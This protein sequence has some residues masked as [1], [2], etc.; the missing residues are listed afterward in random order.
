MRSCRSP[1]LERALDL[2]GGQIDAGKSAA[3]YAYVRILDHLNRLAPERL[4]LKATFQRVGDEVDKMEEK[5]SRLDAAREALALRQAS[6]GPRENAAKRNRPQALDN[7]VNRE[8]RLISP[9]P[10]ISEA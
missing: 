6:P 4:R 2:I 10:M 7:K 9:P 1:A 8:N 5:L 3:A